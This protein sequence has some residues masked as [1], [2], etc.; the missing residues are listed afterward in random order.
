MRW[1]KKIV[2]VKLMTYVWL[3]WMTGLSFRCDGRV[4]KGIQ[5]VFVVRIE[6]RVG[7]NESTV[8]LI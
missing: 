8:T 1:N 7:Y 5:G 6:V 2:G 4:F 3:L